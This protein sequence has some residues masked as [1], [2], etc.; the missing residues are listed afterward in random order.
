MDS[1]LQSKMTLYQIKHFHMW[2][3][4]AVAALTERWAVLLV[5]GERNTGI[6]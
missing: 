4:A 3:V 1:F 6:L 5:V 2:P